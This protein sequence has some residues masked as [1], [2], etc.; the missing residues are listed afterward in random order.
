[1]KT[2]TTLALALGLTLGACSDDDGGTE[3]VDVSFSGL[4][5]LGVGYVYE[6]WLIT[7]DGPV[8]A[9]RFSDPSGLN[10]MFA[11]ADLDA[12]SAY[13]LTIEPAEG[14]DP[15]PSDTHV[16]AGDLTDGSATLTLDHAAALG[17][18]FT[19]AAG[20]FILET[21][22]SAA[23]DDYDQG[24]WFLEMGGSGPMA[25]LTL[26]V[27]PDGWAYEGWV[28]VDGQP[29]STG[30]FTD[31]GAADSD[32]AGPEAGTEMSPPFPG[33][34]F[35]TPPTM[36]AGTTAV[37]SVEPDPDDS[38]MPFA[39]KPLV[40]DVTDAGAGTSQT[41]DNNAAATTITGTFAVAR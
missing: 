7:A 1:M 16:L 36:L 35:I 5:Q 24:I 28:V 26:P 20:T 11:T 25:S 31:A 30:R 21:P 29:V 6:G 10:M 15:A 4:P 40:G 14:D 34:D 3:T 19:A 27:L 32:G 18:D 9:G 22:T 38:P 41:L 33:Q 39:L 17:T 37:I 2:T 23:T 12:T 8:S 13:V